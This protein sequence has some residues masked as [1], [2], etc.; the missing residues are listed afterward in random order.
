MH[1]NCSSI[2]V[3]LLTWAKFCVALN[4]IVN[5]WPHLTKKGVRADCGNLVMVLFVMIIMFMFRSGANFSHRSPN[6]I[7]PGTILV[8]VYSIANVTVM[9]AASLW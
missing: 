3:Q 2:Y 8:M 5:S 6:S 1:S 9:R 4:Y 7:K